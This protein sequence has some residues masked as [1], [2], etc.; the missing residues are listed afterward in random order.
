MAFP[1]NDHRQLAFEVDSLNVGRKHDGFLRREEGRRRLEKNQRL[2]GGKVIE[3]SRVIEVIPAEADNLAGN[4][5][6]Q[7]L[8]IVKR[9]GTVRNGPLPEYFSGYFANNVSGNDALQNS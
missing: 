7:K 9:P 1:R 3:F 4:D 5:R 2:F 6:R 8:Y